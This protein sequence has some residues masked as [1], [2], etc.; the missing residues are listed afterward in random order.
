MEITKDNILEILNTIYKKAQSG[1]GTV[2][3]PI[4]KV[5]EE[6]KEKYKT[7][8]KA[9]RAF[10]KTQIAKCTVSGFITGL[11]GLI[12]LPIS[13]PVNISSVLFVQLRMI[14]GLAY[15]GGF[16]IQSDEV[17]TFVYACLVGVSVNSVFKQIGVQTGTKVAVK[18][19]GKIPGKIFIK[20]NQKLGIR[21]IT[22]AGE[23]GIINLTKAA[24][25]VGGPINAGFDFVETKTIA[26]RAYKMFIE[27][28]FDVG[29]T[30][31]TDDE[32]FETP[33]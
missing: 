20:I 4:E 24:P 29:E 10:I 26:E 16:D 32:N 18:M 5:S 3:P 6:Y 27:Q 13:V 12:T 21:F 25:V 1:I 17:Q 7:D 30:L 15:M 19:V 23:K 9:A 31:P 28:N 14:Q 22:K 2:I 8:K 33:E 11:G